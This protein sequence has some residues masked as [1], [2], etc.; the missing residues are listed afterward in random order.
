MNHEFESGETA[1]MVACRDGASSP[2]LPA[3]LLENGADPNESGLGITGPLIYAV[4]YGQPLSLIDTMAEAG[5][6]VRNSALAVA[7]RAG[8]FDVARYF[9]DKCRID[10]EQDL[11]KYV[12]KYVTESGNEE[13]KK[14]FDSSVGKNARRS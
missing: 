5:A 7:I 10:D 8:R 11:G 4:Q 3:F 2:L 13:L 12:G 6:R 14:G 1:L 9:L